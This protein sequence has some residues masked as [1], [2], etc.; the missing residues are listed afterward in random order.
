VAVRDRY[1]KK[2]KPRSGGT[3]PWWNAA[4]SKAFEYKQKTFPSRFEKPGK[5]QHALRC[6]RSAQRR[7]FRKYQLKLKKRLQTMTNSDRNFWSLAKEIAGFDTEQGGAVPNVNDLAESFALKMSNGAEDNADFY[8]PQDNRT[9]P[10]KSFKIRFP[11]VL[12]CLQRIDASKASNGVGNPFL[13]EC[14]DVLAPAVDSLFKLV[15]RKGVFPAD[16]KIA[17]VTA[18]HKRAAVRDPKNYRPISVLNNLSSIFEGVVS[19][20]LS[21]WVASFTPDCQF[22]FTVGY[23]CADYGAALSFVISDCLERRG[24]GILITTDVKGAFD[25]S[26]WAMLKVKFKARGMSGKALRLMRSYLYRR[27]LKVISKGKSSELKEIFSGVPQGGKWSTDLWNFDVNE[28]DHAI[29][30]DGEL[31]CY[32]DDNAIWYEVT[33]ENRR[34]ILQV[35]NTDLQA[36]ANWAG[37]NKTTFEHSKTFAQV[38]S[39]RSNPFD[40][41]GLIFFENHEVEVTSVQKVVGYTLDSKLTWGPMV[42]G[43]AVKARKRL[44]ALTR[45]SRMLDSDNL[46]TL[47]TMFIRSIM[48]YGN[49]AWMGAAESHLSQLDRVQA[50]AERVGGFTIEPLSARRSA[51]TVAFALKLMQGR[52]KG[53]LKRFIPALEEKLVPD[54]AHRSVRSKK[55]GWLFPEYTRHNSLDVYRRGFWGVL[56]QIWATIPQELI[57]HGRCTG[58]LK[59]KSTCVKFIITGI[60][61]KV[62]KKRESEWITNLTN[63]NIYA[64]VFTPTVLCA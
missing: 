34:F 58:W 35:I 14:A 33:E 57:E 36:V 39:R 25:R 12:H 63:L 48:E 8:Q 38:F 19:P 42:H 28:L 6:S 10:L 20:Q 26:W 31:F 30:D 51:A 15:V 61:P 56:P 24:E 60:M 47:Y 52:A 5:Y 11:R 32:A 50:A 55:Y 4:C 29:S 21:K 54:A 17:A 62:P 23:G 7:A 3:A 45:L 22:G 43:L 13:K 44:A 16:W 37:Y 2:T 9:M 49:L 27:H 53:P 18:V 41:Y 1:V 64:P 46:K 59:I 40:P